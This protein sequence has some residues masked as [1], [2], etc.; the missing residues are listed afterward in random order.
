M[1]R[2]DLTKQ[3]LL[4]D[5]HTAALDPKTAKKVLDLTDKIVKE[6]QMTTLMITHNMKDAITYGN[7]LIM[8]HAGHIILDVKGEEK[9]KLTIEQLLEKFNTAG[10]LPPDSAILSK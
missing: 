10:D 7:R 1:R 2:F 8:F 4:L 3:I 6:N 9:Q 5:E